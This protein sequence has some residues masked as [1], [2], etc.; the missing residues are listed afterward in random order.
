MLLSLE[1]NSSTK[2]FAGPICKLFAK[3]DLIFSSPQHQNHPPTRFKSTRNQ[4][5]RNYMC[6]A[7]HL[8]ERFHGPVYSLSSLVASLLRALRGWSDVTQ[9]AILCVLVLMASIATHNAQTDRL[10]VN[11]R[12]LLTALFRKPDSLYR[13]RAVRRLIVRCCCR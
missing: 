11:T 8:H 10:V 2:I 7:L 9:Y 4:C 12:I 6:Q 1:E 5:A 13:I 3:P